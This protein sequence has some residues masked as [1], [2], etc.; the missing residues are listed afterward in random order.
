MGGVR[1]L[2]GGL[3]AGGLRGIVPGRGA[4]QAERR[5]PAF[6]TVERG[7]AVVSVLSARLTAPNRH[8]LSALLLTSA[9]L[10]GAGVAWAAERDTHAEDQ[11]QAVGAAGRVVST[12]QS[13]VCAVRYQL[14][15]DSGSDYEAQLTV[16]TIDS[17]AAAWRVQFLY[18]GTQHL[19]S[20]PKAVTQ[21]GRKVV[22]KGHGKLKAFNLHGDYRGVNA[23]P[24][25]FSLDGHRCRAE[26]LGSVATSPGDGAVSEAAGPEKVAPDKTSPSRGQGGGAAVPPASQ[27]ERPHPRH[28]SSAPHSNARTGAPAQTPD[29]PQ[30]RKSGG[31]SLAF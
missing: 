15:R 3:F 7:R 29:V 10:V 19:T 5:R 31:F 11:A 26:V 8:R 4:I 9:M 16:A 21:K 24:I 20:L 14:R 30:G 1:A 13:S 18:P 6:S 28:R 23:L 25:T 22:V 17:V 12:A 2:G 27:S